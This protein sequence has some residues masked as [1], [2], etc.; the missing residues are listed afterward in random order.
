[1]NIAILVDSLAVGGAERQ[2]IL[3]VSE[4]RKLG[5]SVDLIYYRPTVEY[6]EMLDRLRVVPIYVAANSFFRRCC[7]L[8]ILFRERNYDVVHGFKMAAEV[9]AAMAGTWAGVPRRFGSFRSVYDLNA[10]YCF[11]HFGLDK[12][13]HG[14]I[15]NS[16]AGA[17]SMAQHT[18]I[19]SRKIQVLHNG[20]SPEMFSTRLCAK[21][22]KTRLGMTGTSVI[23]TMIGRLEPQ[24]NHRMLI[25][26]AGQVL[27]QVP[28]ARFLV[29]GKGSLEVILKEQTSRRGLSDKVIFLGQRSDIAEILAASDIS[30]LTTNYEG[31][32]NVIMESMAAGKPIVCTDYQSCGEIMI[33]ESNALISPCGNVSVFAENVLRLI[34]DNSL[35]TRLGSDAQQYAQANFS[36]AVMAKKLENIYLRYGGK[37]RNGSCGK[38]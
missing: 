23:I 30:V 1:V 26:V 9:Y 6:G 14:W 33:H 37:L 21:E 24:K 15:V 7:R 20:L 19:S 5:H 18:R 2:A 17:E 8:R 11:L 34:H 12:I 38:A 10:N 36:S 29:V 22:A 3:C 16:K 31:L 25:E 4:L 28:Q 32:P 27:R 35:R 13:L